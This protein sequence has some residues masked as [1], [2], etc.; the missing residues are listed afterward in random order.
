MSGLGRRAYPLLL[1]ALS[2][3]PALRKAVCTEDNTSRSPSVCPVELHTQS[4]PVVKFIL[5][6]LPG[7]LIRVL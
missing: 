1:M 2:D 3:S 7:I 4:V 5:S 6:L